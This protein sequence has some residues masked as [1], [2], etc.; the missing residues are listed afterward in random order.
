[1]KNRFIY[2]EEGF[3]LVEVIITIA[4]LG[5][6]SIPI[7]TMASFNIQLNSLAKNQIIATNTAENII[8]EIKYSEN[9]NEFHKVNEEKQFIID[10]KVIKIDRNLE[11]Q[12]DEHDFIIRKDIYKIVVEIT[13]KDKIIEKIISYKV[14]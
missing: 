14:V 9:I 10:T 6:L 7:S 2:N 12:D 3:T 5:I 4:I 13:Y 8:E 1:M 11:E